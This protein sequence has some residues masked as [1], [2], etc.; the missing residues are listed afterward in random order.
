MKTLEI[1]WFEN[2]S[3]FNE[4]VLGLGP[5]RVSMKQLFYTF[6]ALA[7]A[8]SMLNFLKNIIL[9]IALPA[10][11]LILAYTRPYGMNTEEL[12]I[13]MVSFFGRKKSIGVAGEEEKEKSSKKK[14]EEDKKKQKKVS[15]ETPTAGTKEIPVTTAP[16]ADTVTVVTPPP[17]A[18]TIEKI[19]PATTTTAIATSNLLHYIVPATKDFNLE[20]TDK[21]YVITTGESTIHINTT[22]N[23]IIAIEIKDNAIAR[24]I[25][26]QTKTNN[27]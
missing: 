12:L 16:T 18:E 10:F 25:L 1:I 11:L 9:T 23:A 27:E 22:A 5:I 26:S 7:L 21:E 13:D 14:E 8:L 19:L 6:L 20:I 3:A 15:V 2:I 24:I 17:T 4:Q